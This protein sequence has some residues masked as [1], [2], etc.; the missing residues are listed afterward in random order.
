V[1]IVITILI[2]LGAAAL[3]A[4]VLLLRQV[5]SRAQDDLEALVGAANIVLFE[6]SANCL[7]HSDADVDQARGAGALALCRDGMHFMHWIPRRRHL[8]I[9]AV[10]ITA[11]AATRS[12]TRPGFARA[13]ARPMLQIDYRTRGRVARIAW[14]VTD[15]EAWS[16]AIGELQRAS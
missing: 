12:Y 6:R 2:V 4:G 16:E 3:T 11:A 13:S 1:T 9:P 7:G 8:H 5:R 10:A 15:A 14:S